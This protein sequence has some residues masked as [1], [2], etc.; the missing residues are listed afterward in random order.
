MDLRGGTFKRAGFHL[1]DLREAKFEGSDLDGAVFWHA[2]VR[3]TDFRGAK[4]LT[5]DQIREARFWRSAY[6]DDDLR[7]KLGL[8]D[9]HNQ[10]VHRLETFLKDAP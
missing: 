2:D 8:A 9:N 10:I 1:A 4:N 7:K 5:P 6:Y 3:W